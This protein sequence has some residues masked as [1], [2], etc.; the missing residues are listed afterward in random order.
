M[1][2]FNTRFRS[3]DKLEA[4][5]KDKKI[6]NSNH[7]LV[8][9]FNSSSD[10]KRV[11]KLLTF[12]KDRFCDAFII[13]ASS[14][15][16][17][18]EK[19]VLHNNTI[20]SFTIFEHTTLKASYRDHSNNPFDDG[21]NL[22]SN[23]LQDDTKAIILFSTFSDLNAQRL[24]KGV[25]HGCD[26]VV[27][28]GALAADDGKFDKSYIYF[29]DKII[30][31]GSVGLSLSSDRL[32]AYSYFSTGWEPISKEFKVTK[33][34]NNRLIE[35]DGE[36]AGEIY[37]EYIGDFIN[38]NIPYISLQFPFASK[39]KA[40]NMTYQVSSLLDDGS[41][42]FTSNIKDTDTL[43]IS[44]ANLDSIQKGIKTLFDSV[45]KNPTESIFI[46]SSS[47]R[48][49]FIS[50]INLKEIDAI[51]SISQSCGFFGYGEFCT[52]NNRSFLLNH[53]LSLLSLSESD[54]KKE[55]KHR[56]KEFNK[57][58]DLT[59][60]TIKILTNIAK[61]SSRQLQLLNK[62]LNYKIDEG[63]R[64]NRKKES[65]LI[66]N[67]RLAQLGEMLTMIAH[68]WRQPL[69]AISA[70]T[71]GMQVKLELESANKEYLLDSLDHIERYTLHL[72]QTIDDFTNFFKPSKKRVKTT[73]KEIV[74]KSLFI[75]S[76]LLTKESIEVLKKYSSTDTLYTYPNEVIQV[77][78]NLIKNST[79]ALVNRAIK[80][81][82]IFIKTYKEDGK[83]IVE[84]SDNAGGIDEK[85]I[86][87]IFDPYFSTKDSQKSMGLGL[88]MSKFIIEE[89]CGGSL[90]VKN[91]RVGAKFKII[92][93][94]VN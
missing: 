15:G 50:S 74:E 79:N 43:M 16:E 48:E 73:L 65:I 26:G 80:E 51:S 92:L 19:K 94:S 34:Q 54:E 36:S 83:F 21:K 14:A 33:A 35:L 57:E 69:S 63:I 17:I 11:K 60:D 18:Y 13:G 29:G 7:L 66:H 38:N 10:I 46:Y 61:V 84:I 70:T 24:L 49:R 93:D 45:I 68:Q 62:K 75:A 1:K 30:D 28:A 90:E 59:Q 37:K 4:Y 22:S 55:F 58:H 25:E 31:S 20:V 85:I 23:I 86:G 3:I 88:Y 52:D 39:S 8:Q 12:L 53:S 2:T 6:E 42:L 32:N 91:S 44:F 77:V 67:N 71:T 27:V 56:E 76:S 47:A 64:E 40:Q 9:I 41:L 87:K 81:P 5:I 89:S 82:Q 78:L 72:S